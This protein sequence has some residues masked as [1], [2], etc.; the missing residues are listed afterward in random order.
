M[1]DRI[2]LLGA[3]GNGKSTLAKLL[4][5]RL[6]LQQG[7]VTIAPRPEGLDFRTAPA[8][9]PAARGKRHRACAAS[10]AR[11]SGRPRSARASQG[12]GLGT[13]KMMTPAKG[14]FGWRKGRV[15]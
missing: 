5:G 9:R 8:R 15:C 2:A 1:K 14:P 10:H 4:S 11:G 6:P 7:T 13:D 12:M 3:N